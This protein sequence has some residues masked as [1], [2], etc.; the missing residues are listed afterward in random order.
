MAVRAAHDLLAARPHAQWAIFML[1]CTDELG[2][3][4]NAHLLGPDHPDLGRIHRD[5]HVALNYLIQHAP[6]ELFK[7]FP[8][9][10]GTWQK[11][12]KVEIFIL[13]KMFFFGCNFD[14]V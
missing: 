11:A 14:N 6:E 3:V 4:W 8:E 12:S 7:A 10:Y 2:A 5:R 1:Q 13:K 9:E